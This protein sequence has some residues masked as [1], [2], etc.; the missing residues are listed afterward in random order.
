MQGLSSADEE[1][2]ATAPE[3]VAD[4]PA[5]LPESETVSDEDEERDPE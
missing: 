1:P 3:T 4:E 2:K 5:Q